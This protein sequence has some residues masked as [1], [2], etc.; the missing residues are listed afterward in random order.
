M[1]SKTAAAATETATVVI[2]YW[3]ILARAR[4]LFQ[5]CLEKDQ[6]FEHR[7]EMAGMGCAF[8]GAESTNLAPPVL[9]DGDLTLSQSVACYTYLGK[10][11]G[12]TSGIDGPRSEARALQYM[13]DLNELHTEITQKAFASKTDVAALQTYLGDKR[14]KA[15]LQAINRAVSGEFFFG[16]EPSYVDFYADAVLTMCEA[17]FLNPI[18]PK[19]G[20]TLE[21][22]A[23]KL[24]A[25][26]AAIRGR[27]AAAKLPDLPWVP[28]SI[29]I[30]EERVATWKA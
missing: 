15:R 30:S 13:E 20:D 5:M 9:V 4:G 29:V 12:F 24:V 18:K 22:F 3:G 8:F 17:K 21:T 10:K 6:P 23:P 2:K 28:D 25:A 27:P 16:S 26:V 19:S 1:A 14:Y 7:T 11:L